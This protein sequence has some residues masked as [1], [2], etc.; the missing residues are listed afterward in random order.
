MTLMKQEFSDIT[1]HTE[2]I[3]IKKLKPAPYN[4]RK[5]TKE[6]SQQIE[7]SIEK[8]DIAEPLVINKDF[9]VIGG[10]LRLKILKNK[11]FGSVD[12]R[13][14]SRLLDK[15][16]EKE[17]NLRLNKNHGDF[18]LDLLG[19]NFD[20]DFL[21]E[22][23]FSDF[24]L[25]IGDLGKE[26]GKTIE[27]DEPVELKKSTNIVL[28]DLIKI[29]KHRL[30]CGDSTKKEDVEK[31]MSGEKADVAHNDPPY[32]MK[33]QKQG[34]VNDNL[35][36]D[37]LLEFN[38]KWIS[39]QFNYLKDNGSFYCWGTNEP[40][41]DIYSNILKPYIKTQKATFRNLITWDKK[42]SGAAGGSP[43]G[44]DKMRC[45]P[46][47]T[48]KCIF[49]MCG[50]Q[51]FN[52]NADNYY[53]AFEPIRSYLDNE[54]IKNG[55]SKQ[56]Y[57][58]IL[59]SVNNS[60]HH[61]GKSQFRLITE[62]DYKKLQRYCKQNN[63]DAFKK[64]YDELKKEYYSTRAYF[65]NTHDLMYDVWHFERT[66]NKERE[67]TGEHATPKPLKLCERVIK[68]SCSDNG[69]VIDFFLGSG[70]TMVASHQLNRRCYGIEIDPLYCQVI[71]DRMKKLDDRLEI[72]IN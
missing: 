24:D 45:Y 34:V 41:M 57:E 23:G 64:E 65:N 55:W 56:D 12:C 37:D 58:K 40:L 5:A 25:Q 54:R 72:K 49:V 68:S 46:P 67:E 6:Q 31:L 16:E 27:Q 51:G 36:Y 50:V 10:H 33:K 19:N 47:G 9:T 2:K 42:P 70:S 20:I 22:V 4:S 44:S 13:V 48:E 11:V 43:M 29:G 63:I 53:Q 39:L 59:G 18:D 60:Q 66:S 38:K 15:D 52:N 61:L 26:E 1:W 30:L 7:N 8:F 32:G 21:K 35:N 69:L 3:E 14:P 17:L 62:I 28:G 71:I